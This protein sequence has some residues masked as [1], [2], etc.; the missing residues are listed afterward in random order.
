M[1]FK[2]LVP[3]K[4]ERMSLSRKGPCSKG[5]FIFPPLIFNKNII[6]F[7]QGIH[8]RPSLDSQSYNHSFIYPFYSWPFFWGGRKIC[9]SHVF[10]SKDRLRRAQNC[11]DHFSNFGPS[12]SVAGQPPKCTPLRNQGFNSRLS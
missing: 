12:Q 5:H 6:V 11:E 8:I 10:C 1:G 9:I 4:H 7:R 2:H 3:A